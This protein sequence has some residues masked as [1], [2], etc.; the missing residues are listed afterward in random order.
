MDS[1]TNFTHSASEGYT[2]RIMDI[3]VAMPA[4]LPT[5][6]MLLSL[7]AGYLV[8]CHSLRFRRINNLQ[9]RMG[10][11]DRASLA[12][13]TNNDAQLILKHMIEFEFPK[14]YTLALQF[15]IF[16]T[17]GFET[18]S[19]LIVATKNLADPKNAQKRYE[20]T[21]IIFG[22]FSMNPPTSDRCLKA[23]SR[24]NYLHSGYKARGQISNAD[25]LYT[26][27]VCVTE[28]TRFMQLYEW[29][30]LTDME[31]C[32]IG[33]HWKALGD[34]MDIQYK[35]YLSQDSW[36]DGIEFARDITDWAKRYEIDAMK[37]HKNN[38]QA[39]AQLMEMMI[40]HVPKFAKSFAQEV[41]TVLMGDRI[42]DT[43]CFAEPG[44]YASFTAYAALIARRFVV[45]H[46]M[47]P[48]FSPVVFFSEPDPKTGRIQHHEYLV[49]PHYIPA[50]FWNRFGPMSWI[51]RILGGTVPGAEK[52]MPEGYLFEDLG[53]KEK[54]G[55][56]VEELADGVEDLKSRGR[57]ACPFS[58]ACPYS[59]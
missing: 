14:F 48:R 23:I 34:S 3:T 12:R 27:A 24:M 59:G 36:A 16:K 31:L 8:L 57:G 26:L 38:I 50:T 18:I 39:S 41:L 47:L 25:F 20:D 10:Y 52:M 43:F 28:P 56:G 30:S 6:S 49:H 37:P 11:T 9:K 7:L 44:I 15:A 51:T 22:E 32:A 21:V 46:L 54:M 42:R 53:P 45:R 55:K 35:G 1:D 19:K 4:T 29:R 58:G 17:Y 40:W 5:L 33:T 2:T 13:M